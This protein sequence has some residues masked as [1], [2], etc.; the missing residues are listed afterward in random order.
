MTAWWLLT[1]LAIDPSRDD[2]EREVLAQKRL[3][4]D[5]G[6]LTRY[7]SDNAEL[8]LAE[9]ER[10]V[11]FLGDEIT[12][13]WPKDLFAGKPGM[14][15]INR[16]IA[17]QTS[18][19]MLVRF[20]Q[21]VVALKP[22][23]VVIQAGLNDLAGYAGPATQGTIQDHFESLVDLAQAHGIRVVLA[24]LTPTCDCPDRWSA[25]RPAGKIFT[26]NLWLKDFAK[27]RGAVYLDLYSPLA[28]G[29]KLRPALTTDGLLPNVDGYR[30]LMPNVEAA[31]R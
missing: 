16:G 1:L 17:R 6:G 5:W 8:K 29:R 26:L 15:W 23:V 25:R 18:P 14:T 30:K 9:G 19:Q 24:S 22:A 3:L 12:E 27:R 10:R 21:D 11:I 20:R 2:L 13:N 4:S 31:L 7:G 28:E